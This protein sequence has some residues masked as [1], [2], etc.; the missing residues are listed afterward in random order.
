MHDL[1]EVNEKAATMAKKMKKPLENVPP[2]KSAFST[3]HEYF[4]VAFELYVEEIDPCLEFEGDHKIFVRYRDIL[5]APR[6]I[7]PFS[8]LDSFD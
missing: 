7:F 8:P 3:P 1:G 6:A 2:R 4:E 5:W